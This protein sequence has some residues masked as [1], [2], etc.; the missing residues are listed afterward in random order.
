MI[1]KFL[2]ANAEVLIIEAATLAAI[3]LSVISIVGGLLLIPAVIVFSIAVIAFFFLILVAIF[4]RG[5]YIAHISDYWPST[6]VHPTISLAPK[7]LFRV[8]SG[9][10][11]EHGETLWGKENIVPFILPISIWPRDN[12]KLDIALNTSKFRKPKLTA[13]V[14]INL[15]SKK[16]TKKR[17]WGFNVQ[18]LYDGT[19]Q[20]RWGMN[21]ELARS[22][23]REYL[24]NKNVR[25]VRRKYARA[26][27]L[28]L[29]NEIQKVVSRF[30]L[31][32]G[33]FGNIKSVDISVIPDPASYKSVKRF[34]K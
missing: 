3:L 7:T 5:R 23:L 20:A 10:V 28:K 31:D 13:H 4:I 32:W 21:F 22:F 1:K 12:I 34:K 30:K 27:P 9:K 29:A 14:V 16:T 2:L 19:H 17:F 6:G 33:K 8:V 24:T 26:N 11:V 15:K 25:A 18:K